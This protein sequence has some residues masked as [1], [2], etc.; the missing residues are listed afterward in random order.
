MAE[1]KFDY[2]SIS[3]VYNNIN[4][5]IGDSGD[6]TSIAGTLNKIDLD[7]K[8]MVNVSGQA[9]YGDLGNQLLLDWENTSSNFP[10]FIENFNNW[11]AAIAK[12]SG[13]Y[14][15]FEKSIAGFNK[16]NP[17]GATSGGIKKSYIQTGDYHKYT[18]KKL[19][20]LIDKVGAIVSYNYKGFVDTHGEEALKAHLTN[21]K[22]SFGCETVGAVLSVFGAGKAISAGMKGTALAATE[23]GELAGKEAGKQAVKGTLKEGTEELAKNGLKFSNKGITNV[24]SNIVKKEG[25]QLAT[26][27]LAETGDDIA[28]IGMKEAAETGVK[29]I[30]TNLA[31]ESTGFVTK[32]ADGAIHMSDDAAKTLLKENYD[33]VAKKVVSNAAKKEA[34][35]GS[36]Q[37]VKGTIKNGTEE[38]VQNGLKFTNK[39]VTN[40]TSKVSK[41]AAS[42]AT[43]NA[44]SQA[45]ST[46]TSTA[47]ATAK[48]TYTHSSGVKVFFDESGNIVKATYPNGEQVI[49]ENLAKLQASYAQ[50]GANAVK[51]AIN[52]TNAES[53]FDSATN[54][55]EINDALKANSKFS[56]NTNASVKDNVNLAGNMAKEK[57]TST[58]NNIKN[59]FSNMASNVKNTASNLG[60]NIKNS[61]IGN[62]ISNASSSGKVQTGV[63]AGMTA[64]GSHVN[65][66]T[67]DSTIT[68]NGFGPILNDIEM[69][70]NQPITSIEPMSTMAPQDD[71][72][73][74]IVSEPQA[75]PAP[76]IASAFL[77]R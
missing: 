56:W 21:A 67:E 51:N 14:A 54:T 5:I 39:G 76:E 31:E 23:A 15:E 36:T 42:S 71:V 70:E 1:R 30:G 3:D 38:T 10:K 2:A 33:D 40:A 9:I 27:A 32:A 72:S 61:N 44:T 16:E 18:E 34:K 48:Y 28:K 69:P 49:G 11:S 8:D 35:Q 55:F 19:N 6:E 68:P 60:E 62:A 63:G 59:S 26:T 66:P 57:V 58:A 25:T 13:N 12:A 77:T 53:V 22:I 75:A 41:E 29:R 45:A 20:K 47:K 24:T 37:A 74:T 17:L 64:A 65:L 46:M 7:V 4:K 43:N 73:T 50:D 52:S